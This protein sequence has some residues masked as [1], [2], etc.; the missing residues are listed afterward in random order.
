MTSK[1]QLFYPG[2][3]STSIPKFVT[4]ASISPLLLADEKIYRLPRRYKENNLELIGLS[5]YWRFI[6]VTIEKKYFVIDIIR[7][8]MLLV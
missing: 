4:A 1:T 7:M 8:F 5:R 6:V 3:F 2:T